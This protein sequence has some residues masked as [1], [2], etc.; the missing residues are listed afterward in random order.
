VTGGRP[1]WRRIL[2]RRQSEIAPAER[3]TRYLD[4]RVTRALFGDI[5]SHVENTAR[6]EEAGFVICSLARSDDHDVL[7]ARDWQPIPEEAIERNAHGS[8][9]SWSAEFNSSVLQRALDIGG[10]LIQVHSHGGKDPIFSADDVRKEHA[11]FGPFSRLL[12][13]TPCGNLLLG[14]GDARGSFWSAGHRGA[15]VLRRVT[16]VGSPLE[17]WYSADSQLDAQPPR[18]RLARQ[19]V[20]IGPESE[21]KFRTTTVAVV[22]VSGGGSHVVQ[23]LAHQGFGGLVVVDDQVLDETNLG[24][25]VGATSDDVGRSLKVDIAKRVIGGIDQ[26][27]DVLAV[28]ERFPSRDTVAA[29]KEAD[30]IVACLDRFDARANVNAFCRRYLIPLVDLGMTIRSTDE[31]LASADGQIIVTLPGHTCMRCYFI[32]DEIL[33]R[34]QREKPPGYDQ[35]PDAPGD[36]QVVSMNGVLASE[37]CNCVLDLATGYSNGSRGPGQWQYQGRTGALQPS[38]LPSRWDDCPACAEEG[39]GDPTIG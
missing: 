11:L 8:V 20:A 34:E 36:P 3:N 4:V 6:G 2:R 19:T 29:L 27:V 15:V 23:Q 32:T 26:S 31:R 10:T 16:I 17:N 13:D 14:K 7:L 9:L 33:A 1:W 24:R 5:R 21:I 39:E 12:G 35:N 18:V 38:E 25:H 28:P 37:A 22:G 30:I